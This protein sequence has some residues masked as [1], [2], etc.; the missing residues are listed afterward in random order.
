[1]MRRT[2][3]AALVAWSLTV[4]GAQ[5]AD[6]L[7]LP[8]GSR[9]TV[10]P[11]G[12]EYRGPLEVPLS[13]GDQACVAAGTVSVTASGVRRSLRA[14]ECLQVPAPRSLLTS[15]T[16]VVRSWLPKS[17]SAGTTNA[18]SRAAEACSEAAPD[19]LLPRDYPLP[20]LQLPVTYPPDPRTVRVYGPQGQLLYQAT[21]TQPDQG[22]DLPL[23]PLRQATE[24]E[25]SDALEQAI[26]RG[27]VQWVEF[28]GPAG[29]DP[30]A[31]TERA[32]ALL[33]TGLI[34]YTVP[35]Y[36]LLLRAGETEAAQTL[37]RDVIHPCFVTLE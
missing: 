23:A 6:H 3:A 32:R 26:Y 9:V 30:A 18:E 5:T 34:G 29:L 36:T 28:P 16:D 8:A 2:I 1:M 11:A 27:P 37:Y 10:R 19:L 24:V 17:R 15:L 7:T 21:Q 20:T 13:A 25:V 22:F 12:L 35:A 31:L 14:G 33:D 4:A